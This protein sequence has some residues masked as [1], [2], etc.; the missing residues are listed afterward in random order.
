M[1]YLNSKIIF[2]AALYRCILSFCV[3]PCT[4]TPMYVRLYLCTYVCMY[5]RS[6]VYVCVC[7]FLY[8]CLS[9][10]KHKPDD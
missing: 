10:Y 1:C 4:G 7:V 5:V 6:Y 8:M 3:T 9:F 2:T